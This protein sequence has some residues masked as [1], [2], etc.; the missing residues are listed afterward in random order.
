MRA[1]I[2]RRSSLPGAIAMTVTLAVALFLHAAPTRI[3]DG[4]DLLPLLPL[5]TLFIWSVRRPNFVSPAVIFLVGLVQDLLSGGPMGVW[6]FAYLVAFGLAR[7]RDLDSTGLDP[8]PA[9]LRFA[10]LAAIAFVTAWA[11]GSAALG[12]L[13]GGGTLLVE[14]VFTIFIFPV[15]AWAFAR[16]RERGAFS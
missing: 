9:S 13:A 12:R 10:A 5:I 11:T 2:E 16:R 7:H 15:F 3:P 8:G 4:P 14:G 6:A 1:P